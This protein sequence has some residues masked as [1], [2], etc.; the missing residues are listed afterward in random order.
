MSGTTTQRTIVTVVPGSPIVNGLESPDGNVRVEWAHFF[1]QLWQR[2]G[3][4]ISTTNVPDT[5]GI[6]WG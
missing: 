4:G 1:A 3:G 6:G 5:D 2:T